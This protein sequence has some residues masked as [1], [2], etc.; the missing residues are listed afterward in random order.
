MKITEEILL[1]KWSAYLAPLPKGSGKSHRI[2]IIYKTDV[3]VKYFYITS[4]TEKA[5]IIL[6]DDPISYVELLSKDWNELTREK[7][8]IQCDRGHLKEISVKELQ[9]LYDDQLLKY[10]GKI[11]K[12]IQEKIINAVND[13][14]SYSFVEQVIITK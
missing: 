7:S 10:L 2:I 8:C 14:I 6:R 4:K 3:N 5:K 1:E 11:P 9:E 13:S 12:E